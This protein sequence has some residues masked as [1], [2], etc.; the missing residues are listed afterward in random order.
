MMWM[1]LKNVA[2]ELPAVHVTWFSCVFLPNTNNQVK[3]RWKG[4]PILLLDGFWG[5]RDLLELEKPY[6][7]KNC[8]ANIS[9]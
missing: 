7:L 3:Y 8:P 5:V 4:G 9:R 1:W 6:G 2:G